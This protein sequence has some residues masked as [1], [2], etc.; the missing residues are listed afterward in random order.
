VQRNSVLYNTTVWV[1]F[2]IWIWW[3]YLKILFFVSK[4]WLRSLSIYASNSAILVLTVI[5][6]GSFCHVS[7]VLW[8]IIMGSGSV[9]SIYWHLL[10]TFSLNCKQYS[11]IADLHTFQFT[12]A[13]ALGFSV[14]TSHILATDL[15]TGTVTSNHY[16]VFLQFLI[17]SPWTAGSPELDQILPILSVLAA[18]T[19]SIYSLG[20]DSMHEKHHFLLFL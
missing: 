3:F 2:I 16:E 8:L 19:L 14:S 11:V 12:I 20:F 5:I 13:H 1:V 4:R 15:N 6:H 7:L 9:D 17:Q 18:N 10:C